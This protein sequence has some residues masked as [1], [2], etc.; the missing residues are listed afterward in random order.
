VSQ[1]S[2]RCWLVTQ[3]KGSKYADIEGK[4]YEYPQ[5]IQYGRQIRE[6]DLLVACL[7]K[8]NAPDGRQIVGLGRIAKISGQGADRL[9]ATYDRYVK[10][11]HPATF[12][13]VGGD[14]RPNRTI[15]IN[16]IPPSIVERLLMREGVASLDALPGVAAEPMTKAPPPSDHDLREMLHEAVV[17]DLLG[18]A[19]GPEEEILGTSVRDRYLVGKLAPKD[20]LIDEGEVDDFAHDADDGGEEGAAEGATVTSQSIVPSSFGLT[21]CVDASCETLEIEASWGHYR[22]GESE[23]HL[24]ET[25]RPKRVWKRRSAGGKKL[26]T[27][28]AGEVE[29]LVPDAEQPNVFVR[30]IVRPPTVSGE[31]IVT[32]FLVNDQEAQ[33]KNQ[34]EAWL[35]Q[36]QLALRSPDGAEVFRRRPTG[37]SASDDA[38]RA[39]L[40][41][42]YRDKVEFA[43]GHGVSVHW[44]LAPN[45]PRCRCAPKSCLRMTCR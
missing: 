29:P 36:A 12:E 2:A 26:L 30:G 34:D 3:A 25:G 42:L 11:A 15:S 10:L 27:L 22:R 4:S 18:P 40:A 14:P 21:F 16:P 19:S 1:D 33:E 23:I 20:S 39:A 9:L 32:L 7:P 37:E 31:K 24:T 5:R 43:I 38:E 41:M 35:F 13:E 6:G 44:E 8:S 28:Q 17:M 45:R